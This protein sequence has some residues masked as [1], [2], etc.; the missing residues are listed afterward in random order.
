MNSYPEMLMHPFLMGEPN[1]IITIYKG[2]YRLVKGTEFVA[3]EGEIFFSWLPRVG[4]KFSGEIIEVVTEKISDFLELNDQFNVEY[5]GINIGAGSLLNYTLGPISK[6]NGRIADPAVVGDKKI[7]VDKVAFMVPNL[8]EFKG[9]AVKYT[10]SSTIWFNR[11]SFI[12]DEYSIVLDRTHDFTQRKEQLDQR[13]GYI[14]LYSGE[15]YRV[16]GKAMNFEEISHLSFKISTFLS[17]LN[18]KKTSIM[19]QTGYLQGNIVWQDYTRK[20]SEQHIQVHHWPHTTNTAHFNSLW[21]NFSKLWED[22]DNQYFLE[23]A[24]NWYTEA[25]SNKIYVE[26]MI[27]L[28]QTNLELLYNWL[29]I[30]KNEMLDGKD[31]FGL[32]AANKIRLLLSCIQ[33]SKKIPIDFKNLMNADNAKDGPE[34]ITSIRNS[35][36]HGQ[37]QKRK[38]LRAMSPDVKIEALHVSLWYVELSLLFILGYEGVYLN[39]CKKTLFVSAAGGWVPWVKK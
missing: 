31:T 25:N 26:S 24:I 16:D 9:T 2:P 19:F 34:V 15:I 4:A 12:D 22:N 20:S 8:M 29:V 11:L 3:V 36:V 7:D 13:G 35:I 38:K 32:A 37:E 30:E 1:E 39:R 14:G 23:T 6:L 17:F 33:V 28:A 21:Q 5:N 18:G 10:G 27:I